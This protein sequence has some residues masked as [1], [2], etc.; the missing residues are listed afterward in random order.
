MSDD[1]FSNKPKYIDFDDLI[2]T[3]N[4][5]INANTPP[6][7]DF[8]FEGLPKFTFE[9]GPSVLELADDDEFSEP[10]PIESAEDF[11]ALVASVGSDSS[12][13]T[14]SA[15]TTENAA[16][17]ASSKNSPIIVENEFESSISI[18]SAEDF[19]SLVSEAWKI[20]DELNEQK[21]AEKL[22]QEKANKVSIFDKANEIDER[23]DSDTT[24]HAAA[25]HDNSERE[26]VNA[27]NAF[28]SDAKTLADA[29]TANADAIDT[30]AEGNDEA[31]KDAND[32]KRGILPNEEVPPFNTTELVEPRAIAT[33]PD[34]K[35]LKDAVHDPLLF[36]HLADIH[37]S[38]RCGTVTKTDPDTGRLVRDLDASWALHR[39]V[40][41]I[42]FQDPLPSAVVIAG[43]IFDTYQ[44][45]QDAIIDAAR[46]F[47]RLRLAGISVVSIAG[48]HDTP[49]QKKKT[50]AYLVLRHE[51]E[52]I[53]LDAGATFAY[54]EIEHVKAGDIEY[55][56]L[57]HNACEKGGFTEKDLEPRL[58]ASKSVLVVHGVA[59]GDPSLKQMD[60]MKEIPISKWILDMP[61]DYVA[62]GHYH[63]PGWIPGYKGKAAYCGSLENTV[64]SGPDVSMTR[65]PV[66][67]DLRKDG[68][69]KLIM[70]PQRIRN[71]VNMPTL[72]LAG[73][74]VTGEE[75]EQMIV[76]LI[77]DYGE[78]GAIVLHTVKNV[79]KQVL[80]NMRRNYQSVNPNILFLKTTFEAL[81]EVPQPILTEVNEETGEVEPV[82]DENGNTIAVE[83]DASQTFK[84]LAK[85]LEL[86]LDELIA[87]GTI[88]GNRREDVKHILD[89]VFEKFV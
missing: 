15:N 17:S 1:T 30:A 32:Y 12:S 9:D 36:A 60:E 41:D 77:H 13:N 40:D 31:E 45:S 23:E 80:K 52:D 81:S 78:D 4:S 89:E 79:A 46:E 16:Q 76:D 11:K 20:G 25:S 82:L 24:H 19:H 43:D 8:S 3:K 71:I 26:T 22:E 14:E 85:E 6:D 59:A 49:T 57:P 33:V 87:N 35:L 51:F 73:D 44:A 84:P 18:E 37:L 54:S 56:L 61:W 48:N 83:V 53:A 65:G 69:D 64:I 5:G 55:V 38:P 10:A 7:D 27:L 42:L 29:S 34:P 2:G 39:A 68:T 70:H 28:D 72:D 86:G 66:Y 88:H 58:G 74:D 67:V 62:F 75:I 50:P 21:K 63:K 47:Q